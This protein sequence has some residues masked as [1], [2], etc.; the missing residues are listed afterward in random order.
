MTRIKHHGTF[1]ERS[2]LL[3]KVCAISHIHSTKQYESEGFGACD[4]IAIDKAEFIA[5][6]PEKYT[7]YE[8]EIESSIELKD[9]SNFHADFKPDVN[10]TAKL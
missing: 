9:S 3:G 8:D 7:G 10:C 5:T 2:D 6:D 1:G 4:S